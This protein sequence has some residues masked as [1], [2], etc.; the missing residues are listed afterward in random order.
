[1]F[2]QFT[3]PLPFFTNSFHSRQIRPPIYSLKQTKLRKRRV[4]RFAI[5]Y[6]TLFV[7][8]MVLLIAPAVIGNLGLLD[9]TFEGLYGSKF[10]NLMQPSNWNNNDT[11]SSKT[12]SGLPNQ[13]AQTAAKASASSTRR[14]M[15]AF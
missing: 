2:T 8:F 11:T 1:M 3:L 10:Q 13:A 9:S 4:V 5:L 15:L 6:F 14:A 12:G 7:L